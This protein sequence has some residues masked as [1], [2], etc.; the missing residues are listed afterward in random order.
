MNKPKILI[1]EDSP[2]HYNVL[3]WALGE[4]HYEFMR[5]ITSDQGWEMAH[6]EHPDIILLDIILQS[7][8]H[9]GLHLC[10]RLTVLRITF[11]S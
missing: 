7:E 11:L 10:R 3:V 2:S 4:K 9:A 6:S 8:T 1:V 5:A